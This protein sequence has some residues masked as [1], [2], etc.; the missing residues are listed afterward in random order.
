LFTPQFLC[1]KVVQKWSKAA[2]LL[3]KSGTK[4]VKTRAFVRFFGRFSTVQQY[5][6]CVFTPINTDFPHQIH[7][8]IPPNSRFSYSRLATPIYYFMPSQPFSHLYILHFSPS[9]AS[10]GPNEPLRLFPK[11]TPPNPNKISHP[12]F[13]HANLPKWHTNRRL[14]KTVT[15]YITGPYTFH[16]FWHTLCYSIYMTLEI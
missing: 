12:V 16:I 7:Q 14:F 8:E 1:K 10:G 15:A 2:R 4:V 3:Y 13:F 6:D 9:S 5:P 11:T